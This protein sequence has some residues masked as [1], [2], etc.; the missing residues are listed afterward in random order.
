MGDPLDIELRGITKRFGPVVANADVN[1]SIKAGQVLG[2]LGENGAGKSTLM[3]ILSG[4]YRADE[5]EI[6]IDGKAVHFRDA[7]DA[8]RAGIGM[9]HQHFMLVPVFTVAENV[10]LGVEPTRAFDYL[11]LDKARQQVKAISSQHGLEVDP[12]A[13]IEEIPVGLQQRV[14]IIKVLFRSADVLIFDEPTAVL[15]PQEVTE[16]FGIVRS[17][18]DAGKALVFITHK[19]REVLEVADHINVLR[20]GKV[21]GS[22]DPKTATE[23]DLAELMVGRSVRF[24]V[25]KQPAAGTQPVLTV[26]GLT[27]FNE[28]E[29]IAVDGVGFTVHGD[30]VVGIAGVQG[31]GQT[32]L[33][34][35]LTGLRPAIKGSITLNGEDITRAST[36]ERHRKGIAHVPE[37]RQRSGMIGDF[38]IA[39]NMVLDSYYEPRYSSG[40]AMRW[41]DVYASTARIVTDFDVRTASIFTPAGH[42]SGGNQ[43]KM[44]VAR[45]LSRDIKL[46]VASQPTRGVDVG[47]IEYIH[48]RIVEAREAGVGVLIVSTELDEILAISDR[49]LV[50][51]RG[52]IVAEFE[53]AKANVRE[54]GLAMAGAAGMIEHPTGKVFAETPA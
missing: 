46:I 39:E 42:L 51:Y 29:E 11:D 40:I 28:R 19:L 54:I 5:G 10:V 23:A 25:E 15:T 53:T 3:N 34:E 45:E 18:R 6:L 14:E 4:L 35:V 7:K 13:L 50:M 8:I 27:A 44:V 1:L 2:L 21:V 30:E 12:D 49:I 9:V 17:L 24:S 41:P 52:R 48:K 16:F 26:S 37:D 22:A 32:E 20:A 38:T 43:Q 36:R 33:V 47:S 31:N